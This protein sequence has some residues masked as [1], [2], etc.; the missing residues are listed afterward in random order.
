M[1]LCQ[2]GAH[3]GFLGR[4]TCVGR[5]ALGIET[6]NVADAD[7]VAVVALAVGANEFLGTTDL[8]LAIGVDWQESSYLYIYRYSD[9]YLQHNN[10]DIVKVYDVLSKAL[11]FHIGF[12]W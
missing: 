9:K 5:F 3:G 4:S 8:Y 10:D 11:N 12:R 7:G 2:E 6:A 1:Q